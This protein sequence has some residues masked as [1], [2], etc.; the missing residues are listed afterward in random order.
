LYSQIDEAYQAAAARC[1]FICIGCDENCCL[2]RF[3]HHT[4]LEFFHLRE[5]FRQLPM[6]EQRSAKRRAAAVIE[7]YE[8]AS[9]N[10]AP[11]RTMCPLN[12]EQR[13]RLYGYRP[14]ICRMHGIP[15]VLHATGRPPIYGHGCAAFTESCPNPTAA[16]F[17]RTP[18]YRSMAALEKEMRS[19]A[20]F[21]GK[22]KMTVAEMI[23]CFCEHEP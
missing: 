19:A 4:L 18:F 13:C 5:G 1:G 9:Q 14:M 6:P 15:H 17:D 11:P 22:M 3:H 10:E 16:V 2:T 12:V 20:G 21:A 8:T 7:A 23:L